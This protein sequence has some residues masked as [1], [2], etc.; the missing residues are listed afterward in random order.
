MKASDIPDIAFL[1]VLGARDPEWT[2]IW[3]LRAAFAPL[4]DKVITAKGRGLATRKVPLVDGCW[5]GCRGDWNLTNAGRDLLRAHWLEREA[6]PN[7]LDAF[8]D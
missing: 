5:C 7:N 1:L 4:P 2:L 8:E 3:D 6:R